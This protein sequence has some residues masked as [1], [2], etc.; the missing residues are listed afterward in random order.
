MVAAAAELGGERGPAD[1]APGGPELVHADGGAVPVRVG[2]EHVQEAGLLSELP[3]QTRL[4]GVVA[5]LGR[6]RAADARVGDEVLE[7]VEAVPGE[8]PAA[9]RE[10]GP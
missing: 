9:V 4:R 5:R 7:A 10:R 3:V 2:T 1:D 8:G 6:V